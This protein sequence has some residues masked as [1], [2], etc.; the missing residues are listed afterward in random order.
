MFLPSAVTI[1]FFLR[2]KKLQVAARVEPAE[3]AGH[4]PSVH[5][6]FRGHLRIVQIMR[7]HRFAPN[8][9]FA[10]AVGPRIGDAYLIPVTACQGFRGETV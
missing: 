3:I 9:H 4:Q 8:S 10:H 2:P 1:I 7:H 5:N 6:G